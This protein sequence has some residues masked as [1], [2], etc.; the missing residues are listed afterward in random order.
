[1]PKVSVI[2]PV[3]NPGA[4][5]DDCIASLLGQSL[6]PSEYEVI[7]VNDGSTDGTPARL[8]ALATAQPHVRVEHIET[9]AGQDD[10][11]TSGSALPAVSTSIS[12]TTTTGLR[13]MLSPG[14]MPWR[15]WTGQ[16]S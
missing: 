15:P 8:D 5:I 16:T 11:A 13:A 10:R 1:M 3:Y 4:D 2:V 9:P 6:P 14:C 12:S 7:F